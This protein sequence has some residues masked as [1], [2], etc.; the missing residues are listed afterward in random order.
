MLF[1]KKVLTR[2]ITVFLIGYVLYSVMISVK[3]GSLVSESNCNMGIKESKT[4]VIT[5]AAYRKLNHRNPLILTEKSDAAEEKG[6]RTPVLT[7][8]W[9]WG[10]KSIYWYTYELYF[11]QKLIQGSWWIPVVVSSE[12]ENRNMYITNVCEKP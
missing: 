9:F 1:R 6:Y 12:F 3:I 10:A 8:H 5:D 7:V 4:Y 2:V 11:N